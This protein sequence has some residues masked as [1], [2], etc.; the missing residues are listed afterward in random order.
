MLVVLLASSTFNSLPLVKAEIWGFNYV[1]KTTVTYSNNGAE[2]WNLT[3]EDQA[4]G[5]FM[6]NTWQTV[7]LKECSSPIE[8]TKRDEDGNPLA[9][10]QLPKS[11][12][13]PGE[14]ITYTVAYNVE[15]KQRSIPHLNEQE[16]GNLTDRRMHTLREEYCMGGEAWLINDPALNETA[17][18]I[19]GNETN[20]LLI[21]KKFVAWIWNH[22]SYGSSEGPRYPNETLS[23]REGDCDDQ[24]I[25]LITFCRIHGIPSYLQV[26]CIYDYGFTMQQSSWNGTV[27]S[28][29]KH[30][31][32][33]GWAVAYIPPWGWLPVD[34]TYVKGGKDDPLNAIRTGAVT[35]RETIQY[36]NISQRD[37]VASA[38]EYRDFLIENQIY[39]YQ[40]D[41]MSLEPWKFWE[42]LLEEWI[43][44]FLIAIVI[45]TGTLIAVFVY[46][47]KVE[48]QRL[49]KTYS[50]REEMR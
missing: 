2:V 25:L 23:G 28:V 36:M 8:K 16:S 38:R 45:I 35:S 22:I 41:E 31:A 19:A 33:H 6:N 49:K 13:E 43:R 32:W 12:L 18:T 9:V 46:I 47:W 1:I 26:G 34:L 11:K 21:V 5:L 37:Y 50:H 17:H 24:A 39:I 27:T 30:I 4:I 29:L 44:W 20:V 14:N 15:S 40:E 48:R 7:Y 42:E 10:L 3:E